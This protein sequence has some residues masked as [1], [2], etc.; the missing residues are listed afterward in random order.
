MVYML[1]DKKVRLPK[2]ITNIGLLKSNRFNKCD[3]YK[4]ISLVG[5]LEDYLTP[6][7]VFINANNLM[8]F[9]NEHKTI[10]LK[11]NELSCRGEICLMEKR[12][13][14]YK[15]TDYRKSVIS[16]TIFKD[17]EET[18]K[19]FNS[20]GPYF[21]NCIV[22]KYIKSAQ[23]GKT[24]YELKITMK[25]M[26]EEK[27]K[28]IRMECKIGGSNYIIT[29]KSKEQFAAII[30]EGLK[31]AL[32]MGCNYK[33]IVNEINDLCVF[34]CTTLEKAEDNLREMGIDITI[35]EDTR[36]WVM[37]MNEFLNIK[38]LKF[39]DYSIY[40]CTGHIPLLYASSLSML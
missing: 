32:P 4:I 27:W 8:K 33:R 5:E 17:E 38:T 13:N 34:I 6:T 20:E 10:I 7:E 2:N 9:I 35:D 31:K 14:C 36:L 11:Q 21:E 24:V 39:L 19:F 30:A 28:M 22:Q 18:K 23:T 15:L 29:H 1:E 3:Y 37:D 40:N 12:E 16:E 25:K 26:I